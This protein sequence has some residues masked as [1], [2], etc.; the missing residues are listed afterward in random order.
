MPPALN[1]R[2]LVWS[3]GTLYAAIYLSGAEGKLPS[4]AKKLPILT[5]ALSHPG[6]ASSS[7]PPL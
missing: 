1:P 7:H 4:G 2:A 3:S 6:A 5:G